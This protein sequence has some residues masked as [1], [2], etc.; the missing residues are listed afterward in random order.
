MK[1]ADA[2][3]V[4]GLVEYANQLLDVILRVSRNFSARTHLA[5]DML[6]CALATGSRLGLHAKRHFLVPASQS[7]STRLAHLM[8]P[9]DGGGQSLLTAMTDALSKGEIVGVSGP[10]AS[11]GSSER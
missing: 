3:E 1:V 5:N 4:L 2:L 8:F 11:L 10:I 7:T 9:S 6:H